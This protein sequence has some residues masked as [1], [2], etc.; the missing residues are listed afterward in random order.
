MD[1]GVLKAWNDHSSLERDDP[2]ARSDPPVDLV[3]R[4]NGNDA[5]GS[6]GNCLGREA[7]RPAV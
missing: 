4:T 2:G 7:D 6:E 5:V 3:L 1:V